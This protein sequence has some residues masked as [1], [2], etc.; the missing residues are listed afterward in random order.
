MFLLNLTT[1]LWSLQHTCNAKRFRKSGSKLFHPLDFRC[2]IAVGDPRRNSSDVTMRPQNYSW[3]WLNH[4]LWCPKCK[5][6]ELWTNVKSVFIQPSFQIELHFKGYHFDDTIK[7]KG[8]FQPNYNTT[9]PIKILCWE[10]KHPKLS[11]GLRLR[12]DSL[13]SEKRAFKQ[14]LHILSRHYFL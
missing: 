5:L 13:I 7:G 10:R 3:S 14:Y 9:A 4:N 2:A 8:S 12:P 6:I 1:E 11:D